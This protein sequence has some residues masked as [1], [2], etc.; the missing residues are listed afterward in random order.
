MLSDSRYPCCVYVSLVLVS[1]RYLHALEVRYAAV[2]PS[3]AAIGYTTPYN[4][5]TI[6]D[7]NCWNKMPSAN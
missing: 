5:E 3:D 6:E 4:G 1:L 2:E 7:E